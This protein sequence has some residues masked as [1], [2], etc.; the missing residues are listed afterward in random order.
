MEIILL[1]KVEN[2][3]G[4]G[5]KVR[6]KSGYARNFLI[7]EG[8]AKYATPAN[9]AEFEAKRAELEKAA[10]DALE[11]AQA[12]AGQLADLT[13]ELTALAG[14]EGKLFGSIGTQAA[15]PAPALD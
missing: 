14:G 11:V 10:A 5:D 7:P 13:V 1:E 15:G 2:L 12:R 3:G 9:I 6:V 8:K 4:L